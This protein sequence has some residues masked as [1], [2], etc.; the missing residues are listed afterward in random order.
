[1]FQKT[2]F[3]SVLLFLH[4]YTYSVPLFSIYT[5]HQLSFSLFSPF[6]R[7]ISFL[8]ILCTV[9]VFFL[10]LIIYPL[11][12]VH[13]YHSLSFND[14]HG[15]FRYHRT[16]ANKIHSTSL[17]FPYLYLSWH[18]YHDFHLP[19]SPPPQ[20]IRAFMSAAFLCTIAYNLR[21]QH[22]QKQTI[23]NKTIYSS[24]QQNHAAIITTLL[25]LPTLLTKTASLSPSYYTQYNPFFFLPA[26]QQRIIMS[27]VL[28]VI[29]HRTL[30]IPFLL[31]LIT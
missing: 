12:P 9:V 19:T 31:V 21:Q 20:P 28:F 24:F 16:I 8:Y 17:S 22:P 3:S 6:C 27:C 4:T 11:A 15:A 5:L 26:T 30:P 14:P 23:G 29:I 7:S 13:L 18:I 1:M 2:P 10:L 25:S